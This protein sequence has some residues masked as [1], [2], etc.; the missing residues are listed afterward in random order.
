MPDPARYRQA[1]VRRNDVDVIGPDRRAVLDLAGRHRG[2]L[3]EQIRQD[4]FVRRVEVLHEHKGH[5][6]VVRQR[7]KKLAEGLQAPGRGA[8]SHDREPRRRAYVLPTAGSCVSRRVETAIA[9][10]PVTHSTAG[11]R[12]VGGTWESAYLY[13]S[14]IGKVLCP[15]P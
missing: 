6:G 15:G 2:C 8:D 11:T 12:T 9:T 3:G 14:I 13:E 5:A 7:P 4:R 1:M 10:R